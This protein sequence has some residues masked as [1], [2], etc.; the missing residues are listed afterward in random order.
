M[1]VTRTEMPFT[2][3]ETVTGPSGVLPV[4]VTQP[5]KVMAPFWPTPLLQ[6][7]LQARLGMRIVMGILRQSEKVESNAA[8]P[9]WSTPDADP[10][11][12]TDLAAEGEQQN[13]F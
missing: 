7:F 5:E 4:L 8:G 9:V 12:Y 13:T 11:P 10:T 1:L 2:K 6:N 3:S